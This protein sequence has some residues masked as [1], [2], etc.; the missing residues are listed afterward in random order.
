MNPVLAAAEK[1]SRNV[2]GQMCSRNLTMNS[3]QSPNENP[4]ELGTLKIVHMMLY[5]WQQ[6]PVL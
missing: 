5:T 4:L 1:S 2:V 6:H 3:H